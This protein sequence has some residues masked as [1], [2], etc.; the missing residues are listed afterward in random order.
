M[1][2]YLGKDFMMQKAGVTTWSTARQLSKLGDVLVHS[3]GPLF[4]IL[5]LILLL[6]DNPLGNMMCMESSSKLWPVDALGLL[7]V[8]HIGIRPIGYRTIKLVRS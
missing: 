2:F 3:H 7:V 1:H 5:D 8:F 6:L 4:Q